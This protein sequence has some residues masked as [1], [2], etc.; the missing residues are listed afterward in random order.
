MKLIMENWRKFT[1]RLNEASRPTARLKI[2]NPTNTPAIA[3]LN[4]NG[5]NQHFIPLNKV[6]SSGNAGPQRAN[7][8]L[9][10][11]Q[12]PDIINDWSDPRVL[13]VELHSKF[14]SHADD[15]VLSFFDYEG[16]KTILESRIRGASD[17]VRLMLQNWE[18][19]GWKEKHL[20]QQ[21][22]EDRSSRPLSGEEIDS[23]LYCQRRA[24]PDCYR[25]GDVSLGPLGPSAPYTHIYI[26]AHGVAVVPGQ[27][28]EEEMDE[29]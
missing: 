14:I 6:G 11:T 20:R 15:I 5:A 25:I 7:W 29:D 22:G 17:P 1:N 26:G 8:H 27:N 18:S 16:L 12:S 9:I 4:L 2:I 21:P 19:E 13:T 24:N 10:D 3:F 28:D 23:I